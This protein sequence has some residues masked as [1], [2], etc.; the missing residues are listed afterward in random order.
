MNIANVRNS[1]VV[2]LSDAHQATQS[3]LLNY[4]NRLLDQ[5]SVLSAQ[6]TTIKEI[7]T[8]WISAFVNRRAMKLLINKLRE[9]KRDID[10]FIRVYKL[11]SVK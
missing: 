5:Y 2:L 4:T 8:G 1:V 3:S 6:L 11:S 9:V 7:S 10:S